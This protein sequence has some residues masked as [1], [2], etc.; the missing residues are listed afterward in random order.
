MYHKSADDTTAQKALQT[1]FADF[2]VMTNLLLTNN[3]QDE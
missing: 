1:R 2:K 3:Y